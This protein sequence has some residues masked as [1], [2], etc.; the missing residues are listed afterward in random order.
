MPL[1]RGRKFEVGAH[2]LYGDG[3]GRYSAAQIADVTTR[4]DGTLALIR[5]G[6]GLGTVEVH[7]SPKLD[8]YLNYGI[9]FSHRTAYTFTNIAG[10]TV[11]VG[12]G[13]PLFNNSSCEI[14]QANPGNGGFGGNA[15][16]GTCTGDL[17]NIQE[18]TVGFWHKPYQGPKG[19]L[20]WGIQ[21]SYLV[22]NGWSG[23]G[24]LPAGTPGIS[25]KAVDNMV[26]TSFR[27]Y[28]P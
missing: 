7:P 4:P 26:F 5:G 13:S 28:L 21:Y 6:G 1:D 16:L 27:Y 20:R 15:T 25:P 8:L 17:R 9:E 11:P 14:G 23:S 18:G 24:G 2:G 3:I 12:F 10:A 22:R 19:G